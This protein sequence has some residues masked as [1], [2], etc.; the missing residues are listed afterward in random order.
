MSRP[1]RKSPL[2]EPRPSVPPKGQ[3]TARKRREKGRFHHG[4][5]ENGLLCA[6]RPL[7]AGEENS[8]RFLRRFANMKHKPSRHQV[9]RNTRVCVAI[10]LVALAG[11]RAHAVTLEDVVELSQAG[12]GDVVL[13]E[14]I[15]MDETS[16]IRWTPP[17]SGHSRV[18]A[19]PTMCCWRCSA[20]GP[21]RT[22]TGSP[23]R[24]VTRVGGRRDRTNVVR[25]RAL[26]AS[27]WSRASCWCQPGR[28]VQ[29]V[30]GSGRPGHRPPSGSGE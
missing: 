24:S 9:T 2:E 26:R 11:M 18:R 6:Y 15:K 25:G 8:E 17:G 13:I 19:S 3:P 27:R 1:S 16:H 20:V 7:P 12:L 23:Q 21:Q 22:A 28:R 4:S 5:P 29:S 10:A 14:L 30:A